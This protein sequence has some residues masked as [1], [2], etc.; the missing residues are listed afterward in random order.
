MDDKENSDNIMIALLP[1]NTSWSKID[2]PHLTLV[3]SGKIEEHYANDFNSM[4]KDVSALASISPMIMGEVT[5][6]E[7]M[8]PPE[9]PVA[10][11]M[12]RPSQ[13]IL[14]LRSFLVKWDRSEWPEYRPHATIG[15]YPVGLSGMDVRQLVFDRIMVAWGDSNLVFSLR[16]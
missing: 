11:L 14:A 8:G 1:T 9:E 3:Y 10:A 15:P 5:G 7:R 16:K 12:I 6:I 13:E 2:C 4:A